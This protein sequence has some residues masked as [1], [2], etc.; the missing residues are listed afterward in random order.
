M[1]EIFEAALQKK[2]SPVRFCSRILPV[3]CVCKATEEDLLHS[4]EGVLRKWLESEKES[5]SV[6]E[7]VSV[8]GMWSSRTET[9]RR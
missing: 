2:E 3:A 9:T 7:R 1:S 5:V 6:R 4:G 8:S